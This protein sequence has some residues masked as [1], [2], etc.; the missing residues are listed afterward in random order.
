MTA[1]EAHNREFLVFSL[2]EEEYAVDILISDDGLQHLAL[3]RDMELVIVDGRRG[4]GNGRCLP[5]GPLREPL[6]RLEEVDAVLVNGAPSFAM[7]ERGWTFRLAPMQWRALQDDSRFP[8]LPLP[9]SG[10]VHA[11]AGIGNPGRFFATLAEMGIEA[12]PH[13]MAD[14]HAFTA[15]DLAFDDGLPVVM[16]AKDAE[17]CQFLAPADSWVLEVEAQP[18]AGFAAWLD[19]RLEALR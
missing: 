10:P 2:G 5:A 4:F 15:R 7:P 16:T 3:G 17:K 14:H 1:A 11:V 12:R 19:A 9:F 6:A 13:A 8:L 18:V